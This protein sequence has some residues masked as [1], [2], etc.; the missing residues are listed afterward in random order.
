M[1]PKRKTAPAE[2][3]TPAK[4]TKITPVAECSEYDISHATADA[5]GD[6][7]ANSSTAVTASTGNIAERFLSELVAPFNE[8]VARLTFGKPVEYVYN[9]LDYA[10]EPH[11]D[12]I[13]KYCNSTKEI[14]FL[15]M[16]PGPFGMAQNGVIVH[17]AF[18][19]AG[20]GG[21]GIFCVGIAPN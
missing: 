7:A 10:R 8:D 2:A 5:S 13:R 4:T 15:G 16:N 1:P 17:L 11:E 9:P 20:G 3:P 18:L 6:A 19:G 14:L 12:Y 21:G